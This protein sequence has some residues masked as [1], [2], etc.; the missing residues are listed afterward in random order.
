MGQ[1][2][3]NRERWGVAGSKG[4]WRHTRE[5]KLQQNIFK[6]LAATHTLS[7]S[8]IYVAPPIALSS[9]AA[10]LPPAS[11]LCARI[12]GA[13]N[14]CTARSARFAPTRWRIA[15]ARAVPVSIVAHRGQDAAL[16]LPSPPGQQERKQRMLIASTAPRVATV[17]IRIRPRR[18]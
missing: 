15:G 18:L 7:S 8:T 2:K 9:R 17:P 10:I 13:D 4:A 11:I 1:G 16:H 5:S 6:G 3:G 14:V 12:P